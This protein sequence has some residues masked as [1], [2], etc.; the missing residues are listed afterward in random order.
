[1]VEFVHDEES[2]LRMRDEWM[3][4]DWFADALPDDLEIVPSANGFGVMTWEED[5][6]RI[7]ITHLRPG[8]IGLMHYPYSGDARVV[9]RIWLSAD[10]NTLR[11][12][13]TLHD[14]EYYQFPIVNEIWR[15]RGDNP[16]YN[17][18]ACD[19]DPFY[20]DL[21]DRGVFGQYIER[22]AARP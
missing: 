4:R 17:V 22:S 8:V 13:L 6:L 1:M 5:H 11:Q 9:E 15:S 3:A 7:D 16:L 18:D 2:I 20:I 10:G 19:P 21:Y 12:T 14:P